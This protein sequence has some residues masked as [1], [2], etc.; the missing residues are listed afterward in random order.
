M[1]GITDSMDM[2][3]GKLQEL[4]MDREPW[5]LWFIVL[6]RVG[7]DWATELNWT[8]IHIFK[9]M[10][11]YIYIFIHTHAYICV[12]VCVYNTLSHNFVKP[13]WIF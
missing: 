1:D 8:D 7:H 3:L 9:Y 12:H 2:S 10:Y 5:H 6:Q 11:V 13:N 4:L